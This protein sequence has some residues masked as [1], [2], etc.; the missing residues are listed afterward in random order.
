MVVRGG[1]LEDWMRAKEIVLDG[2]ETCKDCHKGLLKGDHAV[3]RARPLTSGPS[4]M[5]CVGCADKRG[6]NYIPLEAVPEPLPEP[7]HLTFGEMC[8]CSHCKKSIEAGLPVFIKLA[9]SGQCRAYLFCPDCKDQLLKGSIK[10]TVKELM[11]EHPELR[12]RLM[13]LLMPPQEGLKIVEPREPQK[14]HGIYVTTAV[15]RSNCGECGGLIGRGE[16]CWY[17]RRPGGKS[18]LVCFNCEPKPKESTKPKVDGIRINRVQSVLDAV[19]TMCGNPINKGEMC[20][21]DRRSS[22][23]SKLVCEDCGKKHFQ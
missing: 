14:T 1:S 22:P 17:A 12:D 6:L 5:L 20:Y 15:V 19:C 23:H 21:W 10:E 3:W 2:P 11:V 13:G 16:Q 8:R 4:E 9:G 18:V 7:Q